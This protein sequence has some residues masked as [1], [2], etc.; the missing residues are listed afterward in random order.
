MHH[1]VCLLTIT[2]KHDELIVVGKIVDSHVREG[3]DDLLLGRKVGALLEFKVANGTRKS[4][5]AVDTAKV[6]EAACGT[7]S[8]LLACSSRQY[9]PCGH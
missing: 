9:L 1:S 4:Q 2:C 8:G 7:D 5:V 3:G 6:D